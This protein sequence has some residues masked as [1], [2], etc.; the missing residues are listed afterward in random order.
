MVV[1]PPAFSRAHILA[2]CYSELKVWNA[3]HGHSPVM[4]SCPGVPQVHPCFAWPIAREM[5]GARPPDFLG[6]LS[7]IPISSLK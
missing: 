2:V 3:F 7:S 6:L 4:S 5:S 1:N